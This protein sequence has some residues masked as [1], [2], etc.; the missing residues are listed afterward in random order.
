M[1]DRVLLNCFFYFTPAGTEDRRKVYAMIQ[2]KDELD[3]ASIIRQGLHIA[4]L[5]E[6]VAKFREK[7]NSCRIDA[8]N[9]LQDMTQQ[10]N[11]I[12]D[13]Y[14]EANGCFT[15]GNTPIV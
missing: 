13:A 9:E 14:R 11:F 7:I 3:R 4:Y 15:F 12:H 5:L 1:T 10:S 6:D 2:R 8:E